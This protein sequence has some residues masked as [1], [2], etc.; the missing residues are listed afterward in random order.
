[1]NNL[2]TEKLK[3]MCS[4]VSIIDFEL[5]KAGWEHAMNLWLI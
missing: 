1:M 5:V 4:G 2:T 3:K